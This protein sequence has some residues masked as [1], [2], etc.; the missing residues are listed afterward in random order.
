MEQLKTEKPKKVKN[1]HQLPALNQLKHQRSFSAGY[2][3]D[4]SDIITE[5]ISLSNLM[6]A[7]LSFS[8]G[9]SAIKT[10]QPTGPVRVIEYSSG[11]IEDERIDGM[12]RLTLISHQI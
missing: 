5:T 7:R 10:A 9:S 6:D 8:N 1:S 4:E 2:A 12:M 3:Y 11:V